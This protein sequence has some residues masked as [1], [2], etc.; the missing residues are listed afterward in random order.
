MIKYANLLAFVARS[1]W[2]MH[3]SK[4]AAMQQ[5]LQF[6][7]A[8]GKRS[9][10]EIEARIDAARINPSRERSVARRAGA[11]AVLPLHGVISPRARLV[12]DVSTDPGTSVDSFQRQFRGALADPEVKAI[13]LDVNSP[14]G[15]VY[16]VPEMSA[17]IFAARGDKPIIAH[18]DAMA[19]SAAYWLASAADEVVVTPSGE[20]GSIGVYT[21]HEDIS[22]HLEGLGVTESFISAGKYKVEG[23]PFEPLSEEARAAMQAD[24]DAY[25]AMFVDSVAQQRGV[26]SA[27][28]RNGFGEGRTVLAKAAV[29]QNMADRVATLDQTLERFGV[30]RRPAA[31]VDAGG[32][33]RM[34][35]RHRELELLNI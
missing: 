14:G 32:N 11:V 35:L 26:K 2:A 27:E 22:R 28:V 34:S 7:V 21:L 5:I 10:S 24:V 31:P 33:A 13:I 4:L 23:N 12:E 16:G 17:E 20:V 29:G 19:A 1:H 6:A 30:S 8:G 15:N 3:P 18:V 25:Y 9:E